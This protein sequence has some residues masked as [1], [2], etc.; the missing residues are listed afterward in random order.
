M[1][2]T[3]AILG[4]TRDD[5][6]YL[7]KDIWF[8]CQV[9]RLLKNLVFIQRTRSSLNLP[10]GSKHRILGL[11]PLIGV[12]VRVPGLVKCKTSRPAR[13]NGF[14]NPWKWRRTTEKSPCHPVQSPDQQKDRQTC[15][16]HIGI[17]VVGELLRRL[18]SKRHRHSHNSSA[19]WRIWSGTNMPMGS[20]L[21]SLSLSRT[22]PLT[23]LKTFTTVIR[24]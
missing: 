5:F 2:R 6:C 12:F 24:V 10:I 9:G 1:G 23:C 15:S 21:L 16:Q 7:N 17:Q 13:Q 3:K 11:N 22:V 20:L 14:L 8:G 18:W 19:H 4:E